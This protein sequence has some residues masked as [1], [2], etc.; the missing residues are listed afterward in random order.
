[1]LNHLQGIK[2]HV[3]TMLPMNNRCELVYPIY[4]PISAIRHEKSPSIQSRNWYLDPWAY[5]AIN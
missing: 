5:E 1:M 3:C 2:I 4:H